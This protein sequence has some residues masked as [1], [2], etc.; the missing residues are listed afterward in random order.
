MSATLT[1][2]SEYDFPAKWPDLL[3]NLV[4]QLQST[5]DVNTVSSILFTLNSIFKRYRNQFQT[6]EI[7]L[8]LKYILDQFAEP[9]LSIFKVTCTQ[10]DQTANNPKA[11]QVLFTVLKHICNIFYSLNHVDI[12]EFFENHLTDWMSGFSK[13]IVYNTT[14]EEL[15]GDDDEDAPGLLHKVQ[16]SIIRNSNLYLDK[17]EEEFKDILPSMVTSTW[18][19]L[20]KTP[21][22]QK[23]DQLVTAAI[24]FLTSVSKGIFFELFKE[25]TTLSDICKNIVIPN[26]KLR[27]AD[28]YVFEDDP[29]EYI[30][31]DV[32]GSDSG[33]RR[34]SAYELVKGLRK[35]YESVI[36]NIFSKY[37]DEMLQEYNANKD[38]NWPA[39]DAAMYLVAALAVTRGSASEGV[40]E[41]NPLVPIESFLSSQV[42][43]ELAATTGQP[44]LKASCLIFLNSFRRLFTPDQ[45]KNIFPI[46]IQYLES[47]SYVIRSY[48]ALC[49]EQTLS[50]RERPPQQRNYRFGREHLKP[51]LERVV[52]ALFNALNPADDSENHYIMKAISRVLTVAGDDITPI[53]AQGVQA[54]CQ[55]LQII[56]KSPKDPHFG[57]HLFESLAIFINVSCNKDKAFIDQFEQQLFPYFQK[58]LGEPN[59]DVYSPFVFQLMSFFIE[60]RAGKLSVVY[61][62]LLPQLIA[63]VM[64]EQQG[65][66]PALSRL[67][68]AYLA[69]GSEFIMRTNMLTG[70]LG[71]YQKLVSSKVNDYLAFYLLQSLVESFNPIDF[72]PYMSEIFKLVFL[73]LQGSKTNQLIRS[74]IVFLSNFIRRHGPQLVI[75][76]V[77]SVQKD[78]FFMVLQ[79]LWIP[80]VKEISGKIERKSCVMAMIKLLTECPAMLTRPYV[81]LWS[82]VLEQCVVVLERL[83]TQ[84][85]DPSQVDAAPIAD[86][87]ASA[88]YSSGFSNLVNA[89]KAVIDHYPNVEPRIMLARGLS[90]FSQTVPGSVGPM[91]SKLSPVVGQALQSYFQA[92]GIPQPY[93]H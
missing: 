34:K 65:N 21:N 40:T 44:L 60:L 83:Q 24:K 5:T 61:E 10:I 1:I 92:S 26:I 12:P 79:S 56:Y 45:F 36:T 72:K 15:L 30:R 3:P 9:M 38:K 66:V 69:Y 85:E 67:I 23:Y 22:K 77:N 63:P 19:L 47:S 64:W 39:K 52:I 55:K 33:T 90:S 7:L 62:Q 31:R 89:P 27:K 82:S 86:E 53:I 28:L 76:Q 25:P 88:G 78:I 87:S 68:E 41:S 43:P 49:I 32:E 11:L 81:D 4:K 84:T 59:A 18:Q 91:V 17:Y 70:I 14:F 35:H 2:I 93:I 46:Y 74:F 71:V 13:F 58:I 16:A 50:M 48:A 29:I 8:E 75:E 57:H 37:I 42:L 6:D 20:M 73:R 54:L 51:F 80:Q